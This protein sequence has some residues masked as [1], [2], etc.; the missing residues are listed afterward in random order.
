M[1]V[2]RGRVMGGHVCR[3][4]TRAQRQISRAKPLLTLL[5]GWRH[6]RHRSPATTT[7]TMAHTPRPDSSPQPLPPVHWFGASQR[8]VGGQPDSQYGWLALPDGPCIVK[9]LDPEL[10]AYNQTLLDHE[11]HVLRRLQELDAPVPALVDL[12]RPD[13]LATRF[14][15][16]SMQRLAHPFAGLGLSPRLAFPLAERLS[17]WVHLLRR[18][19]ALADKAVLVVDLYDANVVVPLTDGVQGQLRLHSPMLIDHAHTLEAGMDMRRPVWLNRGMA[20][21]APELRAALTQDQDALMAHFHRAGA[22][23]P[24]Y[25]RLP[26]DGDS[27]SRKVWAEY[28]APQA[29]QRLLDANQLNPGQAMQY[30][31][32]SAMLGLLTSFAD[33]PEQ[34]RL[35]TVLARMTTARP[36]QRYPSL[37]DAASELAALMAP[38]PLASQQHLGPLQPADLQTP[39]QANASAMVAGTARPVRQPVASAR[40][41]SGSDVSWS[42]LASDLSGLPEPDPLPPPTARPRRRWHLPTGPAHWLWWGAGLGAALGISLPWPW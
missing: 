4:A 32:G 12:G 18:L 35:A 19:Q 39:A 38:L 29:L 21:I 1:G 31:A 15:G 3:R 10:T 14:A 28:R 34:A 23:L 40:I 26:G 36:D 42:T 16:L 33:A 7:F 11:R 17:V 13:W 37:T 22:H 6:I 9:A 5:R 41:D 24:G 20:R 25:S 30:A 2:L 8:L 27:L